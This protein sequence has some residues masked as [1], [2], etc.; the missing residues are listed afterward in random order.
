MLN[1]TLKPEQLKNIDETFNSIKTQIE[2]AGLT[3]EINEKCN[4]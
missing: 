4:L 1:L 2:S 3:A